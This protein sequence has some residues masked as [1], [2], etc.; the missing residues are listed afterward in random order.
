MTTPPRTRA[1]T[2]ATGRFRQ[3]A[4]EAGVPLQNFVVRQDMGCGS[5][6]GPI[7]ATR[8]GYRT[9]DCGVA[10]WSMHSC[11]ETCGVEDVMHAI[12]LLTHTYGRFPAL[13]ASIDEGV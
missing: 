7:V 2:Q 5:T 9:L 6:I 1:T 8:L 3:L 13:D 12:T 10:Q 11:R 4:K